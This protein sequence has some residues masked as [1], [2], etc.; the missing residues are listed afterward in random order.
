MVKEGQEFCRL[1]QEYKKAE[2]PAAGSVAYIIS[3]QWINQYKRYIH[4]KYLAKNQTP[5][6][7]SDYESK[8]PGPITNAKFL[9]TDSDVY[10]HGERVEGAKDGKEPECIDRYIDANATEYNDYE[11]CN[12]EIWDFCSSRYGYDFEVHRYY[13]KTSWSYY[14][15]VEVK[16]KE[17]P[18]IFV[19]CDQVAEKEIDKENYKKKFV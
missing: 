2:N 5:E 15:S 17:I 9:N 14:T 11:I 10:L 19:F 16:M 1:R 3:L 4:Y 7:E 8:H 12:K 6:F 18:I 13:K